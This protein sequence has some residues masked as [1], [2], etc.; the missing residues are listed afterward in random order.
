LVSSLNVS[1]PEE[2]R[3][4]SAMLTRPKRKNSCLV[5]GFMNVFIREKSLIHSFNSTD[6]RNLDIIYVIFCRR[7]E[8]YGVLGAKP[9]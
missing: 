9:G 7:D 2:M 6:Y 5:L 4:I 1:F 3:I 8:I